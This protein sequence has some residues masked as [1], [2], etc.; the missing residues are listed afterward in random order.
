MSDPPQAVHAVFSARDLIIPVLAGMTS[1]VAAWVAARLALKNFYQERIW[2][3]KAT[4]YSTVFEALHSI[5]RWHQSHFDASTEGR[6][7][8]EERKKTLQVEAN[9]AEEDLEKCLAGQI[10]ILPPWFYNRSLKL[11]HD[12]RRVATTEVVWQVY[13]DRSL[14]LIN[15]TTRYLAE[16]VRK[17]LGIK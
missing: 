11:T 15:A 8:A 4:A 9:K 16:R 2:E 3:R 14:A 5:E 13:L 10:W 7:I 12:L 17:D 1:F 6:E